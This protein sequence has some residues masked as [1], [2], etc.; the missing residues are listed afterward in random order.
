MHAEREPADRDD[1]EGTGLPAMPHPRAPQPLTMPRNQQL[2]RHLRGAET[3]AERE[4]L[5]LLNYWRILVK[6]KWT[7]LATLG[8]VLAVTLVATLL[9]TPIYRATATLQIDRDT[10]KVVDVEGMAPMEGAA[11]RDF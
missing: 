9:M 8:L 11:D 10:I 4:E 2:S 5:D 1:D 7:V 3:E 6:R